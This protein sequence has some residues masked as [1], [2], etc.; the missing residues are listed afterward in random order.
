[1]I[2]VTGQVS[3]RL[4]WGSEVPQFKAIMIFTRIRLNDGLR[5]LGIWTLRVFCR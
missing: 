1:M 4:V 3:Q 2:A 5:M